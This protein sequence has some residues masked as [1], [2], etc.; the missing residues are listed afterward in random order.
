MEKIDLDKVGAEGVEDSE[1][2]LEDS[3]A[4]ESIQILAKKLN[5]IVEWINSKE[6]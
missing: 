1:G 4:H 3:Y 5:E 2:Y 6:L